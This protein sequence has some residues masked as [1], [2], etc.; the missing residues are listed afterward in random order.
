MSRSDFWFL[1]ALIAAA[2][3]WSPGIALGYTVGALI[4]AVFFAWRGK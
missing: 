1:A 4:A 3:H 2:P